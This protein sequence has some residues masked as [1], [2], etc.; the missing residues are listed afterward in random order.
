ERSCRESRRI[1]C[2]RPLILM[3]VAH[4]AP[5][6]S[7][8]LLFND[9]A[10]PKLHTLSLHDAL[11]IYPGRFARLMARAAHEC[12]SHSS[13]RVEESMADVDRK[14]TRLNSSHRTISYAVFCLK[15]KKQRSDGGRAGCSLASDRRSQTPVC[16]G[17]RG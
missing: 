2:V 16:V 12:V 6:S 4:P 9:P 10:P 7:H 13:P 15:K 3:S 5:C 14:S 1:E 11:P 8:L 17:P